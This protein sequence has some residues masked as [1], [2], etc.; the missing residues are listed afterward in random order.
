MED[1][2]EKI[3]WVVFLLIW[4]LPR[5]ARFFIKRSGAT[6]KEKKAG[7]LEPQPETHEPLLHLEEDLDSIASIDVDTQK[8]SKEGLDELAKNARALHE[9]AKDMERTCAIHGG[10]T[11]KIGGALESSLKVPV[12]SLVDHLDA[13]IE[14]EDYPDWDDA[15]RLRANISRLEKLTVMLET[16]IERR[17]RPESADTFALLD[18]LAQE[19]LVPYLTHARRMGLAYPTL[20]AVAVSG[21]PGDDVASLLRGVSIAPV[22]IRDKTEDLPHAWVHLTSDATLDVF[23]STPGLAREIAT[24]IGVMPVP[25]SLTHYSDQKSFVAGL[26]GGWLGRI[27]ADTGAALMLG[28]AFCAGIVRWIDR[29]EQSAKALTTVVGNRLHAVLPPLQV[30]VFVACRVLQHLGMGDDAA[31]RWSEWNKRV[32]SPSSFILHGTD[33]STGNLPMKTVL[34]AV[35]SVVDYLMEEP[36]GALGGASLPSIPSLVCDPEIVQRMEEVGLCF[37]DGKAMDVP[38]RVIIGAAQFGV[39]R[40]NALE[41]KVADTAFRSLAGD[42]ETTEKRVRSAETSSLV[43]HMQSRELLV[44]AIVTG[45][46]IAP[47]ANRRGFGRF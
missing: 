42:G 35:G 24:D 12:K 19:C 45:A 29:N 9:R 2:F 25:L 38:G 20:F 33:G 32:D 30:R 39:E 8:M 11:V 40:V 26:M 43:G 15:Q 13:R 18:V 1:F 23:H 4:I 31:N 27:F 36:L 6:L 10:A 14:R 22:V 21:D 41:R 3:G 37:T 28:P 5:V 44:R 34:G 7:Q 47:R 46:A 17:V 16:M